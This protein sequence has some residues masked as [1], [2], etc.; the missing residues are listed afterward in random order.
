[1]PEP[2]RAN[3]PLASGTVVKMTGDGVHAAFEDALDALVATMDLHNRRSPI[4]PP[5]TA[6]PCACVADC[7]QG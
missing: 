2:Y 5:P 1:M 6:F 3:T 4:R 7:R